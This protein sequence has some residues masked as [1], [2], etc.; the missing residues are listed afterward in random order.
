MKP[1]D[2]RGVSVYIGD[3]DENADLHLLTSP[4]CPVSFKF[5]VLELELYSSYSL[6]AVE[7]SPPNQNVS[8]ISGP[9]SGY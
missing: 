1:D 9:Q 5:L 4:S 3:E 6:V 2:Q 8:T 7:T